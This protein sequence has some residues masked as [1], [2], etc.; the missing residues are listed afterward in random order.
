MVGWFIVNSTSALPLAR[1]S[2][3]FLFYR[4]G[5]GD[6]ISLVE[7]RNISDKSSIE[8][9]RSR[10]C[11]RAF[12]DVTKRRQI[13]SALCDVIVSQRWDVDAKQFVPCSRRYNEQKQAC[14]FSQIF[15]STYPELDK[16]YT[17]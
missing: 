15:Y 16:S 7:H 17:R 14:S 2:D 8:Q 3:Q 12:Y 6:T 5:N 10:I 11:M 13:N 4:D 1:T 9:R